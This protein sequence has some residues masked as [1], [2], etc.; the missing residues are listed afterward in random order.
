MDIEYGV[1]NQQYKEW[2]YY[3]INTNDPHFETF[4]NLIRIYG[5]GDVIHLFQ[6]DLPKELHELNIK[7][8]N[9]RRS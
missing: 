9:I 1:F 8:T 5:Y 6:S 7:I 4:R 3:T 2:D